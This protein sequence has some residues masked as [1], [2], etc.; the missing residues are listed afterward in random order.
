MSH[1]ASVLAASL[2]ASVGSLVAQLPLDLRTWTAESYPAVS[3]TS[4]P[5]WSVQPDGSSVTQTANSQP[6]LFYGPFNVSE[7]RVEGRLSITGASD[8]DYVGFAIGFEPGD[9]TN[10]DADYLLIDW[11][12]VDQN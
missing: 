10:P 2:L 9:A 12:R 1:R 5:N 4:L 7:L 3:G 8:D 6:S 11:K